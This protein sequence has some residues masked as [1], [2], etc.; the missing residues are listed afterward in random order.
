MS[1]IPIVEWLPL[2]DQAKS[3]ESFTDKVAWVSQGMPKSAATLVALHYE[4]AAVINR[5]TV[6]VERGSNT[7]LIDKAAAAIDRWNQ[8]ITTA[9]VLVNQ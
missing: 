3:I 1:R 9:K 4:A 2:A 8:A 5:L 6:L 7:V